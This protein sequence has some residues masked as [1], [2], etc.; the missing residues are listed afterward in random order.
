MAEPF[1]ENEEL[2][3]AEDPEGRES[4][5]LLA[6]DTVADRALRFG[7]AAVPAVFIAIGLG[8]ILEPI[9]IW[10]IIVG[11]VAF[12]ALCGGLAAAYGDRIIKALLRA[13]YLVP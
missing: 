10:V 7:C 11:T 2:L 3:E 8:S 13:L 12:G 6:R 1:D 9:D 4:W 5:P